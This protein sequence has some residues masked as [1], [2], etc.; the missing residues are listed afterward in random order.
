[1]VDFQS[2][3]TRRTSDDKAD[4]DEPRDED[5]Q[6]ETGTIDRDPEPTGVAVITIEDG[7]TD[8]AATTAVE[9]AL[10]HAGKTIDS[11][12]TIEATRDAV[13]GAVDRIVDRRC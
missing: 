4:E 3:D 13:Q 2:R 7:T 11:R 12:E 9:E 10:E 8:D 6:T 1:M 5:G